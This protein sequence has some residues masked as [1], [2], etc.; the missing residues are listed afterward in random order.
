MQF[1]TVYSQYNVG[2]TREK[3]I[4]YPI[5]VPIKPCRMLDSEVP[6]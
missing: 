5:F 4:D 2:L 6:D 1:S 3:C